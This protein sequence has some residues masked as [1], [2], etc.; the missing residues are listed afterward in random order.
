MTPKGRSIHKKGIIPDV[1]VKVPKK[2]FEQLYMERKLHNGKYLSRFIKKY[3][4]YSSRNIDKLIATTKKDGISLER[5][6]IKKLILLEK[7]RNKILVYDLNHDIQL[8][9][10]VDKIESQKYDANMVK[11]F[12]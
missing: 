10:A 4:N 8:S 11:V 2:S 6:T 5:S 3:P 12:K 9:K 1:I 7:N